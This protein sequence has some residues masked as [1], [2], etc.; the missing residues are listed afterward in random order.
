M[1]AA[2]RW[3]SSI[4]CRLPMRDP[5]AQSIAAC[6]S[7]N[8]SRDASKAASFFRVWESPCDRQVQLRIG[9]V[10]VRCPLGVVGDP[11]YLHRAELCRQSRVWPFSARWWDRRASIGCFRDLGSLN[12]ASA[13]PGPPEPPLI[14]KDVAQ[15]ILM[16]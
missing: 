1:S 5:V 15:G 14:L 12:R 6:G 3:T 2:V 11:L 13:M 8:E 10:Q 9:R 4:V 7:A 16:S